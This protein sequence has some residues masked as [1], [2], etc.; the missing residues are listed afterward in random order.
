M[1]PKSEIPCHGDELKVGHGS[2]SKLDVYSQ[3]K[4]AYMTWANKNIPSQPM[5][6][7]FRRKRP[8]HFK[9]VWNQRYSKEIHITLGFN[10][11][12]TWR[13]NPKTNRKLMASYDV[14]SLICVLPLNIGPICRNFFL[15]YPLNDLFFFIPVSTIVWWLIHVMDPNANGKLIKRPTDPKVIQSYSLLLN[16]M[17]PSTVID[18]EL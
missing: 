15:L 4:T 1:F 5:T 10:F 13:Q 7:H 18:M 16:V 2:N 11:H 3:I 14:M 6:P 9:F 12:M 8:L 17:T